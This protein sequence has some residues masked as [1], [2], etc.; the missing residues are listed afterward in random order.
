MNHPIR[1][2]LLALLLA[3]GLIT[4]A[5]I[6]R[7]EIISR[8]SPC[9]EGRIFGV[10]GAYEKLRGRAY[11]EIDPT[12]PENAGITDIRLAPRNTR[13]MVEYSMDIYLLRPL[14]AAAGNHKLFAEIPN[15]GGKLFGGL[16]NSSGGN[17]PS[18]SAQA[19]EAFL[20]NQGYTLTWCGW[21]ISAVAGNNN[22]TISVPVAKN[23][24]GSAITGPSYEYISF[25]NEK[26]VSYTLAYAAASPD[27]SK[28]RLMFRRSL[29]VPA[30]KIPDSGWEYVNDRTIRLLPLGSA[31]KQS[32][33]Y[34]FSYTATNPLV[35][36]L[37]LA[38][39]RDY[40]SFLRYGAGGDNPLAGQIRYAFSFAVSQPARYMND[41][42]TLGFNEDEGGRQVFDGIENWLGGGSG[43][44]INYRFAQ[45]G[46]TERNR[47]NHLYPEGIFPFAYPLL[48]DPYTGQK[49]GRLVRETATHTL[50]KVMEINSANEYW[51]K[52]ASLLHTDLAGHDLPD[53]ENVRFYLV[54]GAQH[55]TG[56]SA[57]PGVNQQLQ[58]PT[59]AE[60]LLRALWVALDEWVTR[61]VRPPDSRVPRLSSGT[62][63]LA[64]ARPGFLTGTVDRVVLGWPDIPGVTYTGLVT[65]RYSFDFG[66]RF[67]EGILTKFPPSPSGR[68]VYSN[69]VSKVDAD[70]NEV[71]G[72][73]LPP[74]A[75]PIA[76]TTGWAL[77][78]AGFSEGDGGE[79]SGQF[80]PFQKTKAARIGAGDPRLSLEERYGTH[81]HYVEAVTRVAKELASER[82]L[83][84]EDVQKYIRTARES[85]VLQ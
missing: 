77:R 70:G 68:P 40:I 5:R 37:G 22:L 79:S 24:D 46:R 59:N 13:G 47:Q 23:P 30:E 7:I 85:N 15:R 6:I 71:A 73:R 26:T 42:Q 21:D 38:A 78:R 4:Q 76:T 28:A 10:V 48:T 45:P 50:P 32:F 80:I 83:L 19:G 17:D 55:G 3:P 53:P 66:D 29:D 33:I 56:N 61:G 67:S 44:G 20:L 75:V 12:L 64:V 69:F 60:P 72:V 34:E 2:L 74:V 41:F 25:D 63:A 54:S 58:N 35:A 82:L 52:A 9:F 81:E 39:T 14:N 65:L 1:W 36:G 31:F 57:S 11:G 27:K 8:E 62:A 16:N 84:E 51:V 49:G 43:V 18:L